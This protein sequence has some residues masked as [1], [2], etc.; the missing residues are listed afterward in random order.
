MLCG[1]CSSLNA[2]PFYAEMNDIF[3]STQKTKENGI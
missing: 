1:G 2:F 3:T